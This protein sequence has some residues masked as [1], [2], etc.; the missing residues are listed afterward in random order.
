MS[1]SGGTSTRSFSLYTPF[2]TVP[3]SP[4]SPAPHSRG[5]RQECLPCNKGL[6]PGDGARRLP[7]AAG[8]GGGGQL[9]RAEGRSIHRG[10]L[11]C[12]AGTEQ[13]Q[14]WVPNLRSSGPSSQP[15]SHLGPDEIKP[16]SQIPH[17]VDTALRSHRGPW[18]GAGLVWSLSGCQ[19]AFP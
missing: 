8:G 5:F 1:Q 11:P 6:W 10:G 19:G 2:S 4:C 15:F 12:R 18:Q 13:A 17:P 9:M 7:G 3:Q 14:S 16:C